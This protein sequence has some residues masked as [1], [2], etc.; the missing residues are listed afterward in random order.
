MTNHNYYNNGNDET[1][2]MRTPGQQHPRYP[3]YS[4]EDQRGMYSGRPIR[5]QKQPGEQLFDVKGLCIETGI[6]TVVLSIVFGFLVGILDRSLD[7]ISNNHGGW[8]TPMYGYG[9]YIIYAIL[10]GMGY[11]LMT[12]VMAMLSSNVTN[13]T[14]LFWAILVVPFVWGAFIFLDNMNF[15]QSLPLASILIVGSV[16]IWGVV[17][18]RVLNYRNDAAV[19][20]KLHKNS[21]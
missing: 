21:R 20:A 1:R 11:I 6:V 4:R 5:A 7:A 12:G 2:E 19:E 13:Y 9:Q 15:W 3:A 10:F 14:G 18:G 8:Y 17:P 16:I